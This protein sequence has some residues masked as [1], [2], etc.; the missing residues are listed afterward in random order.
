MRKVTI[1]CDMG[2]A[3]GIYRLGDDEGCLPFITHAN[4]AC[5]FHA[6]DPRVMW[7]TV[8]AAKRHGVAVGSHPGL[9]DLQGF[10]RREM[11]L[12][13]EEI[14]AL[15]IYQTG[16]LKGFLDAE[17]MRLSHIKPH[18]ALYGMA[19]RDPEVAEAIADAAEHFSVPVF[20]FANCAMSEVFGRRGIPFV[21]EFYADLDYDDNGRNVITRE[22]HPVTPEAA[23]Q[24]VRRA[25][26]EGKTTALSG[27][28]VDVIAESIC[29]HSDTPGAVEIAQ[30]VRA[31]LADFI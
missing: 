3:F 2:E 9:P 13:R 22:H 19:Q 11:R 16:A 23:A 17:G 26:A 12:E 1:N 5:G 4:I 15:V 7:R 30:A 31:A 21:S 29:V 6:S 25:V 14:T 8:R 20:A 28:S 24:K 18:G 10:G 27:K